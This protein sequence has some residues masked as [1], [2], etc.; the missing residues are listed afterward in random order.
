MLDDRVEKTGSDRSYPRGARR[1]YGEVRQLRGYLED[2]GRDQRSLHKNSDER[3]AASAGHK[4]QR[5]GGV[6]GQKPC[7]SDETLKAKGR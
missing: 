1:K 2:G 6:G 3:G 5:R 7:T 4:T